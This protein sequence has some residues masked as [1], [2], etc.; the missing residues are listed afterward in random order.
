[1]FTL[2]PRQALLIGFIVAPILFA[3]CAYFTRANVRR[4]TGA[5][6][7]AVAYGVIN[8][9]WDQ[10]AV[11]FGWWSYPAWLGTGRAPITL[12]VLASIVGG[13][14][15]LIGWRIVR[16]WGTKGLVGFL[17]F[18]AAYAVVHDYGGSKALASSQLMVF[19]PGLLP[20]L[21]IML[22]YV[23]GNAAVLLAIRLV[24]GS[25]GD[26]PFARTRPGAAK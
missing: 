13:A 10:A 25:L 12:Y 5:L 4:I 21:A 8:Y 9:G 6:V 16:R 2:T 17:L 20:I 14:M 19:G 15:G 11:R 26:D 18:W 3:L 1:M 24:G 7:G 23:T 22:W